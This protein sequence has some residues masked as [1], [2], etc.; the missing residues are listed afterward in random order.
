MMGNEQTRSP[1]ARSVRP[2]RA[3]AKF[4]LTQEHV[5]MARQAISNIRLDEE[6]NYPGEYAFFMRITYQDIA[7][8]LGIEYA[9]EAEDIY[10]TRRCQEAIIDLQIA[11]KIMMLHKTFEPGVYEI[12]SREIKNY[13]RMK[14]YLALSDPLVK[15]AIQLLDIP[16]SDRIYNRVK[17]ICTNISSDDPWAVIEDLEK[18]KDSLTATQTGLRKYLEKAIRIFKNEE[19]RQASYKSIISKLKT[20]NLGMQDTMQVSIDELGLSER[21]YKCLE[22]SGNRT[23]HDLIRMTDDDL[24]NIKGIGKKS[25]EEILARRDEMVASMIDEVKQKESAGQISLE[26]TVPLAFYD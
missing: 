14:N 19:K 1:G 8:V 13:K 6:D 18:E 16:G 5:D 22:D 24:M 21:P 3:K 10:A 2:T 11:L 25:M 15:F 26:E 7:Q 4:V 17:R 23:L 20:A 12:D 9:V